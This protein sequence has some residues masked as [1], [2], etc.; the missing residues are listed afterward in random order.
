LPDT[1]CIHLKRFRHDFAFS[2]KIS[3]KVVF[4]LHRLDMAP[5]LHKDC[6]STQVNGFQLCVSS[7][8]KIFLCAVCTVLQ[9]LSAFCG[10]LSKL[11]KI[12]A[13]ALA[14]TISFYR[15][16]SSVMD[17]DSQGF[18]TFCRIRIRNWT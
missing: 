4:P 16:F 15:D 9:S 8:S 1:L 5:W 3:T 12:S 17:S 10:S 13:P 2:S 6:V 11:L 18:E 7:S 14:P